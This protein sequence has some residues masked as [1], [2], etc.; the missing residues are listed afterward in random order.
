MKCMDLTIT[1][2]SGIVR[3]TQRR[4]TASRLVPGCIGPS[5]PCAG[6]CPYFCTDCSSWRW[7]G[8]VHHSSPPELPSKSACVVSLCVHMYSG[9]SVLLLSRECLLACPVQADQQASTLVGHPHRQAPRHHQCSVGVHQ[10]QSPARLY[11]E[12]VYQQRQVLPAGVH[13]S[14]SAC[15]FR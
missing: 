4:R 10:E 8:E 2:L 1:W 5:L 13:S 12:R 9:L 7:H 11:G 14:Q 3:P 15:V 6:S